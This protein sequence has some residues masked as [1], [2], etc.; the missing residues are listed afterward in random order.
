LDKQASFATYETKGDFSRKHQDLDNK[1]SVIRNSN[2]AL[3]GITP[4]I[5]L[6]NLPSLF[7]GFSSRLYGPTIKID[8]RAHQQIDELY[9]QIE[10]AKKTNKPYQRGE[11][12]GEAR[13]QYREI[14]VPFHEHFMGELKRQMK[15]QLSDVHRLIKGT[16]AKYGK[17]GSW[18]RQYN[19]PKGKELDEEYMIYAVGNF[20]GGSLDPYLSGQQEAL[21]MDENHPTMQR[22]RQDYKDQRFAI[23]SF[24]E[25][26]K[27]RMNEQRYELYQGLMPRVVEIFN[28]CLDSFFEKT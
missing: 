3:L 25:P 21:V 24:Q 23:Q 22:F 19:F 18:V 14:I 2:H 8:T 12:W 6:E 16:S 20:I 11:R 27:T 1:V 10:E 13:S 4:T 7:E 26:G 15:A 9:A 17:K 5:R 28:K